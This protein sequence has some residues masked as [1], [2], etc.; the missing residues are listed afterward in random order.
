MFGGKMV[1]PKFIV[2]TDP[3]ISSYL[4]ETTQQD[5]NPERFS[6]G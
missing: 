3:A 6:G 1:D 5:V 4:D 2:Q